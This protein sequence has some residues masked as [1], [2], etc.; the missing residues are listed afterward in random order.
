MDSALFKSELRKIIS[1]EI[2][3]LPDDYV[4]DSNRG[5]FL[6]VSSMK[7]FSDARN[8]MLYCSVGRE[9][10]TLE[11]AKAALSAGKTVSFPYCYRDGLMHAR[12][13]SD[14][15]ELKPAMLGIPAPPET[16]P[17]IAPNELDFVIV[18]ALTFDKGGYRLGYGGGYYDRYLPGVSGVTVGVARELLVREKVPREPHDVAVKLLVTEERV[19][20]KR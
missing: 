2:A 19:F 13:V 10:D 8:I 6:R 11:L 14:L 9:T 16:S 1:E 18:P 17:I 15:N 7:E 12:I 20:V 4:A 5:I 3:A